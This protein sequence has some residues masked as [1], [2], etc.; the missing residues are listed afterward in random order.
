MTV[1]KARC[2]ACRTDIVLP[3][4][5]MAFQPII[6]IETSTVYAYEALVRPTAGGSAADVLRLIT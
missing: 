1:P 3:D 4:F 5:T 2:G 6:D